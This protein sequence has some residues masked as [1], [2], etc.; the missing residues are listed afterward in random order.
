[1]R[2]Y[3]ESFATVADRS[4]CRV[5]PSIG[6]IP[7]SSGSIASCSELNLSYQSEKK[8][9]EFTMEEA[10]ENPLAWPVDPHSISA[11]FQDADYFESVGSSHE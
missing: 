5:S 6:I 1:M 9:R 2:E 3:D 4:G 11:Y 8:L 7:T 10:P